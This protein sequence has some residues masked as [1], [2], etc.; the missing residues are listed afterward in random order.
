[1]A[2]PC[3]S[4]AGA[5]QAHTAA[6]LQAALQQILQEPVSS[7]RERER[8][9]LDRLL[10]QTENRCVLFGAGS[11][12]RSVLA[13]LK[14]AGIHPLAISDNNRALWGTEVDGTPFL[15]PAEAARQFGEQALFL[16][17]I[18]NELHNFRETVH[19]LATLG[20]R[21]ISSANPVCWRFA[22]QLLPF[23]LYDLPHK[24]Y[25]QAEQVLLAAELWEDASS[26]LDYLANIR[27]RALGDP[28]GLPE[29]AVQGS[30]FL[31]D[32]FQVEPGEVVLDCGAFDGDTIRAVIDRQREFGAIEAVEP[33]SNSFA[34]LESYLSTLQPAVR[35]RI[36]VHRCAI[37]A[38]RGAIRFE[39][40]GTVDS[41]ISTGDGVEV[42]MVPIDDLCAS[43]PVTLIKMDIEGA[44]FDALAG[45]ARVIQR[46]RPILAICVYHSQ[47]DLWRLPLQMRKICP[48]SRMYLRSHGGDGIQTVAYAIPPGRVHNSQQGLA[49]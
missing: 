3:T 16:V 11:L 36:R 13:V 20:C 17:T 29:P 44:E 8:A 41:R 19:Q 27:L 15:P 10:S 37:G 7:V 1:M 31:P 30:Y 42:D 18:R 25:E 38:T 23:L 14:G 21:F 45:G 26:R 5:T 22:E 40:S 2:S 4:T 46:D 39:N 9:A 24:V 33:D 6:G 48:D 35:N 47:Q 12:G 28:S 32:V 43:T 49:G 34:R